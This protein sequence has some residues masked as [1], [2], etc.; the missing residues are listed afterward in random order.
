[1]PFRLLSRRARFLATAVAVSLIGAPLT[2][3]ADE[4]ALPAPGAY[5]AAGVA[6]SEFAFV[7]AAQY[8]DAAL[9]ADPTNPALLDRA[10]VANIGLG[11]IEK[12]AG[13]ADRLIAA[14]GKSQLANLEMCIRDRSRPRA[15]VL[16][17]LN[18]ASVHCPNNQRPAPAG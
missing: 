14:G 15:A 11:D 5:L 18:R 4:A 17:H 12:A 8:L 1:M 7:P 2:S 10:I 3:F 9:L 16:A 13:F 6:L